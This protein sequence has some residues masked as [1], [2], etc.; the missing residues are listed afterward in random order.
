MSGQ[1]VLG[2]TSKIAGSPCS[3]VL[4]KERLNFLNVGKIS[5]ILLSWSGLCWARHKGPAESYIH[6][7]IYYLLLW[8]SVLQ[9]LCIIFVYDLLLLH[10]I[11]FYCLKLLH[12]LKL[13]AQQTKY[14]QA[15]KVQTCE[16]GN[17]N[18][19]V[20]DNK[21]ISQLMHTFWKTL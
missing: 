9:E 14:L 8:W 5:S 7:I 6:I 11:L 16:V 10:I 2:V 4:I 19:L 15:K 18:I 1:L 20:K 21:R 17:S 3:Q 12:S 13:S